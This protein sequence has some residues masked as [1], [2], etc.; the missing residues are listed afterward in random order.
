MD[1]SKRGNIALEYIRVLLR[2][3]HGIGELVFD[4]AGQVFL[5]QLPAFLCIPCIGLR[6]LENAFTQCLPHFIRCFVA[7]MGDIRQVD[8]KAMI[9]ANL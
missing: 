7:E 3:E 1:T 9:Q 6:V 2:F 5:V 8:A 4:V